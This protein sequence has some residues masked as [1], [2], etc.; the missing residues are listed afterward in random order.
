KTWLLETQIS[1]YRLGP[2]FAGDVRSWLADMPHRE[3]ARRL[4]GGLT[5]GEIP[6]AINNMV[7]DTHTSNDFIMKPLPNHLFTRD[8]SCWIY[9]GVSINP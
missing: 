9:N 5:Y 7:V 4:S 2:T 8:T 6:A 1:D 3:L